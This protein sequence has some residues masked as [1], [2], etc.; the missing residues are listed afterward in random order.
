[1]TKH[2]G[3][4]RHCT[5]QVRSLRR[6]GRACPTP[7]GHWPAEKGDGKPSPY[8]ARRYR[9]IR[10][11]GG[12]LPVVKSSVKPQEFHLPMGN[13][14][15]ATFRSDGLLLGYYMGNHVGVDSRSPAKCHDL[16]IDEMRMLTTAEP[17]ASGV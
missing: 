3:A 17:L 10:A 11:A 7:A 5:F 12:F 1:M 2:I 13:W 16:T 4:V 14:S 15:M 8:T 6:R 9:R